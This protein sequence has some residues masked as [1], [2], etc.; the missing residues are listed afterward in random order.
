MNAGSTFRIIAPVLIAV[1]L[2]LA[3]ASVF[4]QFEDEDSIFGEGL[5]E[6]EGFEEDRWL[7]DSFGSFPGRI[8]DGGENGLLDEEEE[9]G[10]FGLLEDGAG[11]DID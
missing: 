5:Q 6:E 10:A 2:V 9:D 1:A 11:E 7:E 3:P 4:A 8:W